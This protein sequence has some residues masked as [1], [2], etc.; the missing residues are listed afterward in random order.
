MIV[1]ANLHGFRA[2]ISAD[3][4]AFDNAI[5]KLVEKY[6]RPLHEAVAIIKTILEDCVKT[7]CLNQV[8]L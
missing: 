7:C 8:C 3:D 5:V 4:N 2:N 6:K 1:L